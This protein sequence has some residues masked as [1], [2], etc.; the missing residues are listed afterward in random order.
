MEVTEQ[1][2]KLVMILRLPAYMDLTAEQRDREDQFFGLMYSKGYMFTTK[3]VEQGGK[4]DTVT[5]YTSA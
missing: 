2:R 5:M 3:T 4:V 1:K